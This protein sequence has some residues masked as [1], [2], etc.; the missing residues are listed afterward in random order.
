MI[1]TTLKRILLMLTV[2]I[3]TLKHFFQEYG[4]KTLF[5]AE[6]C[7]CLTDFQFKSNINSQIGKRN[8]VKS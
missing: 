1:H 4:R 6:L 2:S 7:T 8:V 5:I 3:I